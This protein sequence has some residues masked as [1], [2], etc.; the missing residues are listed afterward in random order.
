LSVVK[1]GEIFLVSMR[2]EGRGTTGEE[3]L[4]RKYVIALRGSEDRE[5]D[6]PVVVCSTDR[7]P[8]SCR[9]FAVQVEPGEGCFTA[10]TKIDCR[11]GFTLSK[12]HLG[13]PVDEVLEE[14][15]RS[16]DETLFI[17]LEMGN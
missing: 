14:T 15:L 10:L 17:G 4:R 12:Q 1:R 9:A 16:L 3:T 13:A 5:T 7:V 6:V 8:D 2:F 11:W